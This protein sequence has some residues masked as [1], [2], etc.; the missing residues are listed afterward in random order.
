MNIDPCVYTDEVCEIL[1][2]MR[3]DSP[4]SRDYA[5][6]LCDALF[7]V[8]QGLSKGRSACM[9]ASIKTV[10][11]AMSM[12]MGDPALKDALHQWYK[13]RGRIPPDGQGVSFRRWLE[14]IA[15]HLAGCIHSPVEPTPGELVEAL[16]INAVGDRLAIRLS[17]EFARDRGVDTDINCYVE[18]GVVD[19]GVWIR[20]EDP[21]EV[22]MI[23]QDIR[24]RFVKEGYAAEVWTDEDD[25]L[26]ATVNAQIDFTEYIRKE[27]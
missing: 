17:N 12:A 1:D 19:S 16:K 23:A 22:R 6:R 24:D 3:N 10:H 25:D 5:E 13:R 7:A 18:E 11:E 4:E 26:E 27:K 15:D 8:S 2:E 21:E 14:D 9:N 20:G